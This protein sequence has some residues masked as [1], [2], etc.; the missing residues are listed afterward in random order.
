MDADVA[1]V[2]DMASDTVLQ[3]LCVEGMHGVQVFG[4]HLNVCSFSTLVLPCSA[5]V[6]YAV[7]T[8]TR[9]SLFGFQFSIDL[10]GSDQGQK[11]S[12]H[13]KSVRVTCGVLPTVAI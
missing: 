9:Y 5:Y 3:L 8:A 12:H 10:S 7:F 2:C 13:L 11:H 4:Y 1:A 6:R